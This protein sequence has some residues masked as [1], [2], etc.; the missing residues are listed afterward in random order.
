MLCQEGADVDCRAEPSGIPLLAYTVMSA[1]YNLC[2]TTNT[3]IALLAMGANPTNIPRDM[4]CDY[5][6][7]AKNDNSKDW[8]KI[9]VRDGVQ[10]SFGGHSPRH[11]ISCNDTSCGKLIILSGQRRERCKLRKL[12][13][14]RHSSSFRIES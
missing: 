13:K 6:T 7:S 14:Q 3:L 2:A 10:Q 9:L 5:T 4:W 1:D 8:Q 12:I 11:S